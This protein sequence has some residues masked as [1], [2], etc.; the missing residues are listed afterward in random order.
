MPRARKAKPDPASPDDDEGAQRPSQLEQIRA[1]MAAPPKCSAEDLPELAAPEEAPELEAHVEE[2]PAAPEPVAEPAEVAAKPAVEAAATG[3][4]ETAEEPA[5]ADTAEP[6]TSPWVPPPTQPPVPAS[7]AAATRNQPGSSGLALGI[8]LV[9]V[10]VFFLFMRIF[11]VDLSSYGWPLYVIIPGL[12]LLVV[13]F[14]SLGTGALVPGGII[15]MTGLV[16]AY[17]NATSDWPSWS[18]AWAL[19]VPGG[20]GIG[21]FL[22]GLRDRERHQMKQGRTLMFWALMIFLIGFVLFESILNVS[23]IDYGLVGRAALPVLLI[24]IGVTLLARSWQRG[25]RA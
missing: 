11:E 6:A 2:P 9:V 12:T 3:M 5:P 14:I 19:V 15:T 21:I 22:Q 13:G 16:L 23:G 25:R 1:A 10:G 20:V 24:I 8:V 7:A 18:Y 17:Q 4:T